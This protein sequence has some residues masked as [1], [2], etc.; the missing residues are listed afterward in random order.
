MKVSEKTT[1]VAI[2]HRTQE[3]DKR[4][5]QKGGEQTSLP[6]H[7]AGTFFFTKGQNIR[8]AI[9]AKLTIGQPNDKYEQEADAVAEKV[10][11]RFAMPDVLTKKEAG[12][13]TKSSLASTISPLVQKKCASCEQ[14]EKLQKKGEEDLVQESRPDLS[15]KPIFESNAEPPDEINNI[16]R[17]CSECEKE[18]KVQKKQNSLDSPIASSHIESSLSSSKGGGTSMPA[19]TKEQMENSFGVDFSHVRLHRD[20]SA[21]QMNNVLGA[22]A[23]TQGSDIYFNSG[24]Y[25]TDTSEGKHLLAHELTHVVQQSNFIQREKKTAAD[26]KPRKINYKN[27]E[28]QN[29]SLSTPDSLGWESKLESVAGGLY[30]GW[31]DLWK[32]GK[33]NEFADAVAQYQSDK[34]FKKDDVDGI[35]G[36]GTWAKIGGYGEAVA[37]IQSV[38]WKRSKDTC[39]IA[40]EER[41]N[42]G[43]ELATG[44]KF[45]LAKDKSQKTFNIILQS[46]EGR[47]GDIDEVYR[48]AGAAGAMVYAGLATYV[49]E[50]DIWTG[51]LRP[52][53]PMQVWGHKD[54]YNLL[55]KGVVEY[56]VKGVTKTRP[57]K[58]NDANFYGTSFVFVRYDNP[59]NPTQMLVRHFDTPEWVSKTSYKV[60]V[61]A[62]LN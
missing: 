50:A 3:M 7:S 38:Q 2:G 44:K 16:Q 52:G 45:Q 51:G 36:L 11:Q 60:W 59:K 32:A 21:V 35:L 20:S 23:F 6:N 47:M 4:F 58:P 25:N 48:G 57:I 40:S 39:T 30:K 37:G 8:P 22:Q 42:R 43:H 29:R 9:Q 33:Y 24:K 61:A 10:V 28:T 54:A 46:I 13:Q 26:A 55:R 31:F 12:G 5:F 62:N 1:S 18:E 17:K 27:A 53:A 56:K 15:R 14:E 49:P 19:A 34:G 41:I